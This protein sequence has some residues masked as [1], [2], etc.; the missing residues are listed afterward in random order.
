VANGDQ[1]ERVLDRLGFGRDTQDPFRAVEL[2][3]LEPIGLG[4]FV[5][6]PRFAA[7]RLCY[8]LASMCLY[9]QQ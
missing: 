4:A 9:I 2:P 1:A 6:A 8:A 5:S 7:R 3:L